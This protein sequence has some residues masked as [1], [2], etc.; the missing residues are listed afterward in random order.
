MGAVIIKVK[1]EILVDTLVGGWDCV[2][3][4]LGWP[5]PN[6]SFLAANVT[7][8]DIAFDFDGVFREGFAV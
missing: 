3:G 5:S 4:G 8:D 1:N 7:R 2:A 6:L